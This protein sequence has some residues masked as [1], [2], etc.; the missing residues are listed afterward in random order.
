MDKE[1]ACALHLSLLL[2]VSGLPWYAGYL[3]T[4]LLWLW[5]SEDSA[6]IDEHGREALNLAFTT[7]AIT[8][9]SLV[10]RVLSLGLLS[11]LL[12][13]AGGVW[14]FYAVIAPMVA[15]AGAAK[16]ERGQYRMVFYRV[17]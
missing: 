2:G 9:L 13:M 12:W 7:I 17:L 14:T 10:L 8:Y 11:P 15:A 1:C 3:P 5:A 6:F 4:L 16:G